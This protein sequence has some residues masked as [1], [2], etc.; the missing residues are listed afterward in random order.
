MLY[1]RKIY[2]H[3]LWKEESRWIC[4]KVLENSAFENKRGTKKTFCRCQTK[5]QSRWA[6]DQRKM[7]QVGKGGGRKVGHTSTHV[8]QFVGEFLCMGPWFSELLALVER[9][10]AKESTG[11]VIGWS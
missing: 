10:A 9:L 8:E 1:L 6:C 11:M 2:G 5:K 4:K 3:S 7:T